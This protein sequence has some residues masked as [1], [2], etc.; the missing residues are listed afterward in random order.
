VSTAL[1]KIARRVIDEPVEVTIGRY[2]VNHERNMARLEKLLKVS[3][4][5]SALMCIVQMERL[6]HDFCRLLMDMG[7]ISR[8][9]LTHTVV[10][11]EFK[12]TVGLVPEEARGRRVDMFEAPV[13]TIAGELVEQNP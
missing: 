3:E 7:V 9:A 5:R 6:S 13:R 2:V 1:A 10:N 11:Y 12:A 4:G 8:A